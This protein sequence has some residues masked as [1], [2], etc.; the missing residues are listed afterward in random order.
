[1]TQPLHTFD[2]VNSEGGGMITITSADQL[3][4]LIKSSAKL[5]AMFSAPWCGP[6]RAVKPMVENIARTPGNT[7]VYAYVNIEEFEDEGGKYKSFVNALP[8]FFVYKDGLISDNFKGVQ[9]EK[10][11][12]L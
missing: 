2:N 1:M 4:G 10:L 5:I 6:C 11:R 3:D 8:T 7:N 12:Q 9:I